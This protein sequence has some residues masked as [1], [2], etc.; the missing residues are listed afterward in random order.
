M[1]HGSVFTIEDFYELTSVFERTCRKPDIY[2]F[3]NGR[4]T[5]RV[6]QQKHRPL[7]RECPVTKRDEAGTVRGNQGR[8]L[9]SVIKQID[10]KSKNWRKTYSF[11]KRIIKFAVK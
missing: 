9:F 1:E 7:K 2:N 11:V 10:P 6:R 3:T 5:M 4:L 8:R